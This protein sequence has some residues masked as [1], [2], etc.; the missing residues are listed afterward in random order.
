M[1]TIAYNGNTNSG[2][3]SVQLSFNPKLVK[4]WALNILFVVVVSTGIFLAFD[5]SA[6]LESQV[7]T[8]TAQIEL[9]KQ[10]IEKMDIKH[11]QEVESFKKQN[12]Q[13]SAEVASL[14]K[15]LAAAASRK[16]E[17]KPEEKKWYQFW[18]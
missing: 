10:G 2:T 14:K 12:T 3:K 18:K 9:L 8:Q 17:P 13:L 5:K 11:T 1:K 6:V 7:A 4:I 16:V 15:A